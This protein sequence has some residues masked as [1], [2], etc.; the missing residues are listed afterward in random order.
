L[1]AAFDFLEG[2]TTLEWLV[3]AALRRH[4]ARNRGSTAPH[5]GGPACRVRR[6]QRAPRY[7]GDAPLDLFGLLLPRKLTRTPPRRSLSHPF[8]GRRRIWTWWS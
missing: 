7:R 6:G 1:R 5:M 2:E 3:E 4:R 8:C